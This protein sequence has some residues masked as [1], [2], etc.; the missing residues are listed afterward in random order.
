[1][2]VISLVF[3]IELIYC[4]FL[5]E[6]KSTEFSKDVCRSM[7]A[8][9]DS[10]KSGKLGFTEFRELWVDIRNWKVYLSTVYL[11]IILFYLFLVG[12]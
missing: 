9:M 8:M 3:L 6:L 12:I 1:M 5:L 7:V 4:T 2:I 11:E 10:D